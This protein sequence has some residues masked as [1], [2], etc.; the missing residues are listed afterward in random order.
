MKIEIKNRWNGT[1]IFECEA[2]SIRLAVKLAVEKR[3]NLRGSDLRGSDLR[4]SDLR[5]SI[6]VKKNLCTPLRMLLDQP[7]K[8]RAYK[9]VLRNGDS[10]IASQ[11]GWGCIRYKQ[12]ECFEEKLASTDDTRNCAEGI[13]LA[14]LDWCMKEWTP[15]MRILL[16]EF[17]AKDIA[18]IP[19]ATD[20]KFRVFR[21]EVVGEKDLVEVGLVEK[22]TTK[23]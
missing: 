6:G 19:T 14:T 2:A 15:G 16:A 1:L 23:K 13:S 22:D 12:G 5:G 17:T 9:L 11:R 8:I 7:G 4:D 18:A 20:G 3:I 10:P 21:C